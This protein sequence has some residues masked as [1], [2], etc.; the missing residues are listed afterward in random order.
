MTKYSPLFDKNAV[1]QRIVGQ[2]HNTVEFAEVDFSDINAC[3]MTG[4]NALHCIVRWGDLDAAQTLI[5][6]GV[7]V[8]KAGDL[9]YTPL[10]VACMKGN[11]ELV[12]LLIDSGADLFAMNEGDIP[13]TSARLAGHDAVCDFMAPLMAEAQSKEPKI[14]V[15]ARIAQLKREVARLEAE[16]SRS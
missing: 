10:H 14:W 15:R 5:N 1:L 2:L 7:D 6:A 8:N 16:L 9:G 4:D 11:I 3:S 13:F 12:K